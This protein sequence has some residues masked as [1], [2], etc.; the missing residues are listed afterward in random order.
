VL[1]VTT[2]ANIATQCLLWSILT[3]YYEHYLLAL[4][5][6]EAAIWLL[7]ALALH[8]C[9]P[10]RRALTLSLLLNATSFAV[11]WFLPI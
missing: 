8:L 10:T 11:G 3:R 1:L 7:E 4:F 6:A 2:L 5:T 9:L